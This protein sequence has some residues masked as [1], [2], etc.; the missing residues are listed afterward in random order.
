MI[1]YYYFPGQSQ[2]W[3]DI[4]RRLENTDVIPDVINGALGGPKHASIVAV[5]TTY[6]TISEESDTSEEAD[7][8]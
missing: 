2:C 4:E 7:S 3:S 6:S 1:C 5:D 8:A